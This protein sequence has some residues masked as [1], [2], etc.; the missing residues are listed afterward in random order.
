MAF[1]IPQHCNVVINRNTG[2]GFRS[3]VLSTLDYKNSIVITRKVM[4]AQYYEH[5]YA[6]TIYKLVKLIE[7]GDYKNIN[8]IYIDDRIPR[9]ESK[10]FKALKKLCADRRIVFIRPPHDLPATLAAMSLISVTKKC[11][12]RVVKFST[13][14]FF[15]NHFKR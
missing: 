2:D 5:V 4:I 6:I 9:I 10:A 15:R 14:Q 7:S 13:F 12:L 11:E 1:Y 8:T 3:L